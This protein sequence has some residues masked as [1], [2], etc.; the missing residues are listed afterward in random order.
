L[1]V[2][3]A[4]TATALRLSRHTTSYGNESDEVFVASVTEPSV[5][6]SLVTGTVTL[7]SGR[8]ALCAATLNQGIAKCK[9]TQAQ[10]AVGS[11]SIVAEY[12][13]AASLVPSASVPVPMLV[14]KGLTTSVLSL[15]DGTATFGREQHVRFSVRVAV[16]AG[17]ANA[18]GTVVVMN[19]SKKVCVVDLVHSKG[20]CSL[21][22]S[23]LAVGSHSI[24]ARYQGSNKLQE[25]AS[26]K[27][28]LLITKP[29]TLQKKAKR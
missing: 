10:L 4:P 27:A 12:A 14:D 7:M 9:L 26:R 15:S 23:A 28:T 6:G 18:P 3:S 11:H 13:G 5:G 21:G 17:I 16:P 24:T 25:S 20:S 1:T 22:A 8:E 2:E 19:G 29:A